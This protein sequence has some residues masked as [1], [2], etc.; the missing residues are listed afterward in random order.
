M[1]AATKEKN[2]EREVI[3][4]KK[5]Y[6]ESVKT[7]FQQDFCA[8]I[9]FSGLDVKNLTDLRRSLTKKH[10]RFEVVKNTLAKR[11]A[12]GLNV[13]EDV[14]AYLNG[15]TA[16]AA[17]AD[18]P[19]IS[20]ILYDFAKT[21]E[22]LKIKGGMLQGKAIPLQ[23][24]QELATLPPRE[25]LLSMLCSGLQSPISGLVYVLSATLS[26]LLLTLQAVKEQKETPPPA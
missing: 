10:V 19:G 23:Q 17:G 22:A 5:E 1:S 7:Y 9:S 4:Q 18:A 26:K 13:D 24:I 2:S 16:C 12:D 3:Q 8:F 21:N 11:A 6:V 14:K 15:T 25:Q 20:K